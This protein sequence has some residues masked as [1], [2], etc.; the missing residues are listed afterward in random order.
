MIWINFSIIKQ[1]KS[2]EAISNNSRIGLGLSNK[3][4]SSDYSI[5]H[6]P[7]DLRLIDRPD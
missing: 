3:L 4:C 5:C 1:H 7:S 6:C 2:L